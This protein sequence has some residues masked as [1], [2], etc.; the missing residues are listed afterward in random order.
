MIIIKERGEREREK[1]IKKIKEALEV[2]SY[3]ELAKERVTH[4]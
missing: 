3:L 4:D 2:I 1:I